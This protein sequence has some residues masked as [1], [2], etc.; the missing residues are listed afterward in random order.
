MSETTG[1]APG[2]GQGGGA[3]GS[4]VVAINGIAHIYITVADFDRALPFYRRLLAL[5][6]MHCL[7]EST[8]LYYCIGARTGVGIRRATHDEPFDQ[9]RAGLHHLCFRA[10]SRADVDAVAA[11]VVEFG[12]RLVHPP[13]EDDWAPGYYSVLFE[14]PGGTR[15]EV[16]YVPGRGHMAQGPA[17]PLDDGLQARLTEP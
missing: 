10:R 4:D 15:L 9:Y 3:A 12:G 8:D 17:R 16:N 7:V 11:R 14:D 1:D 6:D 5:F 2:Q 13:Q